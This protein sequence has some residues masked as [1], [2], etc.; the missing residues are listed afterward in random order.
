MLRRSAATRPPLLCRCFVF[1]LHTHITRYSDTHVNTC[2]NT[3]SPIDTSIDR[4]IDRYRCTS[5]YLYIYMYKY[6]HTCI[7]ICPHICIAVCI[8]ECACTN[9]LIPVSVQIQTAKAWPTVPLRLRSIGVRQTAT[10]MAGCGCAMAS[11]AGALALLRRRRRLHW[12]W[13]SGIFV[14]S[15]CAPFDASAFS[16]LCL[17]A[18]EEFN[19]IFPRPLSGEHI[20]L[21]KLQRDS[22]VSPEALGDVGRRSNH[23]DGLLLVKL[24]SEQAV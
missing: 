7:Y 4:P 16:R 18:R 2:I 17:R 5:V 14:C 15:H 20:A 21:S 19:S 1:L 24:L 12:R 3:L 22:S 13:G 6:M 8:C 9:C 23:R 11:F 10:G